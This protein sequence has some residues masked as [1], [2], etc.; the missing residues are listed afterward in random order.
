[1][2]D[3]NGEN[4][5]NESKQTQNTTTEASQ[6][7]ISPSQTQ[8]VGNHNMLDSP[9]SIYMSDSTTSANPFQ[10]QNQGIGQHNFEYNQQPQY[11]QQYQQQPMHPAQQQY[12]QQSIV[13]LFY[14][15]Y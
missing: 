2:S 6:I 9:Y 13:L 15:F 1:M 4:Q 12:P 14:I 7:K 5:Q 11:Q 3:K 10:N 8:D